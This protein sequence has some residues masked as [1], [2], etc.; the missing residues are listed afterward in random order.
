MAKRRVLATGYPYETA[1][2]GIWLS[3]DASHSVLCTF[4]MPPVKPGKKYRLVLE[5]VEDEKKGRK[6][7]INGSLV[8][9]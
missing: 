6:E 7:Q 9:S 4:T 8:T 2:E 3:R 5:E 1:N